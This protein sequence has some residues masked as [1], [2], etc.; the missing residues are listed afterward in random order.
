MV[1]S[2]LELVDELAVL[3]IEQIDDTQALR[4][5]ARTCSRLQTLAEP[6]IYHSILLKSRQNTLSLTRSIVNRPQ[7][8]DAVRRVEA[9][10]RYATRDFAVDEL[11]NLIHRAQNL[12]HLVLESPFCNRIQQEAR[13]GWAESMAA[14]LRPICGF[15]IPRLTS[16]TDNGYSC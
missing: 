13:H 5:L 4:N 11:V 14:L 7:R 2:I 12:Q 1:S 8:L 3:I 15:T 6:A 10:P 16:C 9:R